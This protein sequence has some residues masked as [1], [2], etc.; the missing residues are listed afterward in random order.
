[1]I[2]RLTRAEMDCK[3]TGMPAELLCRRVLLEIAAQAPRRRRAG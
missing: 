3:S 2:D 1:V